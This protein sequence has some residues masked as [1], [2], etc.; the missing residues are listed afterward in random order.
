MKND[1]TKLEKLLPKA[2][3]L[4]SNYAERLGDFY[5]GRVDISHKKNFGQFFT[6]IAVAN[7]MAQFHSL[8][9]EK[10]KILDPGCGIGILS[11]ALV[12]N[13]VISNKNLKDIELVVFETDINIMPFADQCFNYLAAWLEEKKIRFT[14]FLCKSDFILH[15]SHILDSNEKGNTYDI[16]IANPPYFKLPKDDPRTIAAKS[17][18]HGQA[19]IYSLFLIIATKLLGTDGKLIFI[20]P[21]S[22]CSGNYFRLF[23]ETFF[24]MVHLEKIH[25][26]G[27]R[28]E[29]FRRDK[30]L[31]ENIIIVATTKNPQALEAIN[32]DYNVEISTSKGAS[33]LG[34]RRIKK[35]GFNELVNLESYQKVLHLPASEID[36]HIISIFKSWKGSLTHYGL[37]ISTGPVVNFRSEQFIDFKGD[38]KHVPLV[39]LHNIESMKV[40]WPSGNARK[41]K[42]KGEYIIYNTASASRLVPNKNYVLLRRFSAKDD[43]RRLIAAPYFRV[44]M[45][46]ASMLG[47]ENHLNYIY[48]KEKE[49]KKAETVGLAALLNSQL[50]DLY[51]RTFNGNINV[52]A[53]EL[54]DFPL[55]DFELIRLLG[56]Q[57]MKKPIQDLSQIDS[58]VKELFS[59]KH[60]L[61]IN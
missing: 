21:R 60:D 29:T 35:F 39:W 28:T 11:C 4:P 54:R 58:M 5:S 51:F 9:K 20:T 2:E 34:V 6:P 43:H 38:Q 19:N 1:I 59:I 31:Q 27:S 47:I 57:I 48:H 44:S 13:L 40:I 26:F 41:G 24:S 12:E 52:S 56:D 49:L 55:P 46:S 7:F 8:E 42:V 16:V 10:I 32:N 45:P 25:L 15:N 53:T 3:E 37:E 22:F 50:F 17:I 61:F 33:D 30:V 23:R 18:I 36:E 14:H